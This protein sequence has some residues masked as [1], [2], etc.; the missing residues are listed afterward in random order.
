MDVHHIFFDLDR[1]LW[2]FET[3]SEIT[4]IDIIKKFKLTQKG[5]PSAKEFIARYKI[6]NERLWGLYRRNKI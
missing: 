1:T 4:L 5:V 3:N 6:H 2:D